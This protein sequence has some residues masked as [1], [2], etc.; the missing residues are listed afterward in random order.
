VFRPA[1]RRSARR[2]VRV[3]TTTLALGASGAVP[4][5]AAR[6]QRVLTVLASDTV[7]QSPSSI[8]AGLTMIRLE[9]TGSAR[10]DLVVHR[11]PTGTP[12]AEFVRGAAGRPERWFTQWSF[13]GPAV[14]HDSASNA[15]SMIDLRPGRYVLVSYEVDAAGRPRG[16]KYL[17]RAFD[18]V[19]TSLLIPSRFSVADVMIKIRDSRAEASGTAR[20]GPRTLQLENAGSRPHELIVGRLKPGRSVADVATWSRDKDESP[21]FVYIGGV[22]P[23]SSGV[24]TQLRFVLQSG[25]HVVFCPLHHE[26]ERA[27]DN[28]L[29]AIASFTV[30]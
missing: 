11:V 16:T 6:A 28:E 19:A 1:S 13:G 10:R 2:L 12:P 27:A 25:V 8:P 3:V 23:L 17:W 21:P 30:N 22:T 18:A 7:L 9:L 14:P 20:P 4:L 15:A 5:A 24:R 29:G 26:R